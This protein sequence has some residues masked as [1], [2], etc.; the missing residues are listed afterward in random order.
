MAKQGC[1]GAKYSVQVLTDQ[2]TYGQQTIAGHYT[3]NAASFMVYNNT[4]TTVTFANVPYAPGGSACFDEQREGCYDSPIQISFG[5]PT[6]T[7]AFLVNR[8]IKKDISQ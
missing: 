6:H 7:G 4:N 5:S 1:S 8:M 2:L 3:P